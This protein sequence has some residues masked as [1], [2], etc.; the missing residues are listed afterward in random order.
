MTRPLAKLLQYETS[1][2]VSVRQPCRD[3]ALGA[4]SALASGILAIAK[5]A[6][7]GGHIPP[8]VMHSAQDAI[9]ALYALLQQHGAFVA[10]AGAS[11]RQAI[12]VAAEAMMVSLQVSLLHFQW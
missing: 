1:S 6:A 10:G 5:A 2:Q 11:G 8:T 7:S 12:W 3:C 9:A 4:V